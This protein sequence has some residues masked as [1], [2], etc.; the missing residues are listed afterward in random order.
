[1][2]SLLTFSNAIRF[3]SSIIKDEFRDRKGATWKKNGIP[4]KRYRYRGIQF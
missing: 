2:S 4:I 3:T 1:M